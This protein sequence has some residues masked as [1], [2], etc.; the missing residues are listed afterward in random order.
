M[1]WGTGPRVPCPASQEVNGYGALPPSLPMDGDGPKFANLWG[2]ATGF[3]PNP[4]LFHLQEDILVVP[5][6]NLL[7]GRVRHF[8]HGFGKPRCFNI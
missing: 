3:A 4:S 1:D 7:L 2:R 8:V 6:F 5:P